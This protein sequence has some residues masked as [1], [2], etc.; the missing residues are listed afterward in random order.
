[1]TITSSTCLFAM[2]SHIGKRAISRD[3]LWNIWFTCCN[4]SVVHK[5]ISF[6]IKVYYWR[7]SSFLFNVMFIPFTI[8]YAKINGII[9]STAIMFNISFLWVK[10][11]WNLFIKLT[12]SESL[13]FLF[14]LFLLDLT[15]S[16]LLVSSSVLDLLS[17]KIHL[18]SCINLK[19]VSTIFYQ[20]FLSHQM[21]AFRKL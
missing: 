2:F 9:T 16:Y 8:C 21:I 19:L 6:R 10:R 3:S 20:I 4:I 14:V 11:S 13:L 17:V 18:F 5:Y 12:A 15:A 1:M 7:W